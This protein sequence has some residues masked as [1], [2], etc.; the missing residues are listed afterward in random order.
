MRT[1]DG[2]LIAK[3]ELGYLATQTKDR[4][5]EPMAST[6][7]TGLIAVQRP[8]TKR[9]RFGFANTATTENCLLLERCRD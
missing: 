6:A 7:A 8:E 3:I 2:I 4:L 5:A 1:S 9:P